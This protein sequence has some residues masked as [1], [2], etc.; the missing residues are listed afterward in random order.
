MARYG[1]TLSKSEIQV[2]I[3]SDISDPTY[4]VPAIVYAQK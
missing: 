3:A 4:G 2:L 1:Y